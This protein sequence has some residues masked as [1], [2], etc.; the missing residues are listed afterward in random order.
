M[1]SIHYLIILSVVGITTGCNKAPDIQGTWFFDYENTKPEAFPNPQYESSHLLI[2][3]V[4]PRYGEIN[5]S[6]DT[7]VLGGAVCKIQKINHINGLKCNERGVITE[8]SLFLENGRLIVKTQGKDPITA[9][10]GRI[11]QDPFLVYGIDPKA[12]DVIEDSVYR[13]QVVEPTPDPVLSRYIGY[14]R[15]ASFNAFYDPESVK[16]EGR[17]TNVKVILNYTEAQWDGAEMRN[18]LSSVQMLTFDC[19]GSNYRLD[20]YVQFSGLNGLGVVVADSGVYA[21]DKPEMKPV[22]HN[23][24]NEVLYM[25]VCH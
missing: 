6:G 22:P 9:V 20:R 2:A 25:R 15:T 4:E 23:S 8:L 5:V 7:V 1:R 3:D 19:P 13:Q 16:S 21:D 18:A 24:V 17:F 11:K 14:A 10:F 12:K